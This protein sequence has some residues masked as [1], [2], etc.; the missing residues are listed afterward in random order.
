MVLHIH[1]QLQ[2]G[3]VTVIQE[4]HAQV[5]TVYT[6]YW[7]VQVCPLSCLPTVFGSSS[8]STSK[9]GS[10]QML[11]ST[12]KGRLCCHA[13]PLPPSSIHIDTAPVGLFCLPVS[14]LFSIWSSRDR[15]QRVE[16]LWKVSFTCT[17]TRS[18]K[19]LAGPTQL[20]VM[21]VDWQQVVRGNWFSPTLTCCGP[22]TG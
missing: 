9:L 13:L 16:W 10:E 8:L 12:V 22:F 3:T 20:Q 14:A 7:L 1:T 11:S 18:K 19:Q 15:G 21:A 5:H 6:H 4:H 17:Q 2:Y